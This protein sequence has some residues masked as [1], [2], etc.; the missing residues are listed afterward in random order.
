MAILKDH[1]QPAGQAF[2]TASQ[3]YAQVP[4]AVIGMA[5]RLPGKSNSIPAL[6]EFLERGG[7]ASNA[8]PPTRFNLDTHYVGSPKPNTMRS[9][10]GMFLESIDPQEFDAPFFNISRDD[11][12]AMDPQQRQLLEVVYEGLENA[13]ITLEALDGAAVACFVGSFTCGASGCE[14]LY[15]VRLTKGLLDYGDNL[16]RDPE[17]RP[18]GTLVGLGRAILSNRISHFLN[19]K[20]PRYVKVPGG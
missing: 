18:P 4:I 5:C 14:V 8:V 17:D 13:G 3:T 11:A 9:P 2:P 20:G 7:V 15:G 12:I 10:G 6:W 19:I 1:S 16:G